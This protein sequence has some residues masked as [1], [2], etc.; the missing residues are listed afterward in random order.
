[1]A[2]MTIALRRDPDTGR[3]T[4]I[5]KLD[6]EADALPMEHEQLHRS[7]VEQLIGRGVPADSLGGLIIEREA[8]HPPAARPNETNPPQRAAQGEGA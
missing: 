4:I 7:L 3:H 5:V 6:S 1:M 2:Q 8:A